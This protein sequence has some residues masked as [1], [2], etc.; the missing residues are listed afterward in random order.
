VLL[1]RRSTA[2]LLPTLS[3]P[4]PP[5]PLPRHLPR[6]L[7]LLLLQQQLCLLLRAT[8]RCRRSSRRAR[9]RAR[10]ALPRQ[11]D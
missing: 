7:L 1:L 9:R 5:T 10:V 8:R 11:R 4:L 6:L 3:L 2:S